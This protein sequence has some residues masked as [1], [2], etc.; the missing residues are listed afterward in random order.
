MSELKFADVQV[1]QTQP[2]S[3]ACRLVIVK[4]TTSQA[5]LY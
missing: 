5:G 2:S 3:P 1:F 4:V